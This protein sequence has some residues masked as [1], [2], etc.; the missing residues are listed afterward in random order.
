MPTNGDSLDATPVLV[1]GAGL[2]RW[3]VLCWL[4]A[5][6]RLGIRFYIV[7]DMLHNDPG[8]PPVAQRFVRT[9]S[10]ELRRLV[11]ATPA[12]VM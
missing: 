12:R 2:V 3:N 7:D 1:G 5:V 9:H 6:E 4:R 11:L 10:D 8:L